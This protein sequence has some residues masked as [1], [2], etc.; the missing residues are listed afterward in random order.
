M[1]E[2][3][4]E[5]HALLFRITFQALLPIEYTHTSSDNYFAFQ[6]STWNH[7][8][9]GS[10]I[11]NYNLSFTSINTFQESPAENNLCYGGVP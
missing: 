10:F 5:G 6:L 3:K 8:F 11:R 7:C 1:T 2:R 9:P 4:K